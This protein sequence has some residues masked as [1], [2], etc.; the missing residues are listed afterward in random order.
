MS[1]TLSTQLG[2]PAKISDLELSTHGLVLRGLRIGPQDEGTF[3][4]SLVIDRLRVQVSPFQFFTDPVVVTEVELENALVVLHLSTWGWGPSDWDALL[5]T[6]GQKAQ[7]EEQQAQTP[8]ASKARR[9]VIK[10]LNVSDVRLAVNPGME[11]AEKVA[12]PAITHFELTNV[13]NQHPR[14]LADITRMVL[15]I[16]LQEA[17]QPHKALKAVVERVWTDADSELRSLLRER[18]GTKQPPNGNEKKND[19]WE[20]TKQLWKWGKEQSGL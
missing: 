19:L 4:P 7:K 20:K 16:L 17:S 6:L 9:Y 10:K 15:S 1:R 2:V 3:T 18:T 14:P 8:E 11:S 12:V 5:Q 13:G